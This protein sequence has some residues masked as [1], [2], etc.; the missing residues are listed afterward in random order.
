LEWGSYCNK[1]GWSMILVSGW[2][3]ELLIYTC[4]GIGALTN[5]ICCNAWRP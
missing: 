4:S 1:S 2:T 3:V 5:W